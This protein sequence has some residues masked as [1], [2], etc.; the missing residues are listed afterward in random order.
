MMMM[1][2]MMTMY[3]SFSVPTA[4]IFRIGKWVP[5]KLVNYRQT[6]IYQGAEIPGSSILCDGS[7]IRNLLQVTILAL[8]KFWDWQILLKICATPDRYSVSQPERYCRVNCKRRRGKKL[9]PNLRDHSGSWGGRAGL[10]VGRA[11]PLPRALTSRGR[12]KRRSPTGHTLIR[13]TVE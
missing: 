3:C 12:Q 5:P 6:L 9:L 4:S 13:S 7:S 8:I 10:L 2:M 1:M 11:G